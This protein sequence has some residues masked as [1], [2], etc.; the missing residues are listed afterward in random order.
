MRILLIQPPIEDFYITTQRLQPVGLLYIASALVKAGHTAKI[1]DLL[2]YPQTAD[3]NFD[4][5]L[6]Y[7]SEY[8][9]S[10]IS[11]FRIFSQYRRFGASTEN[12]R[13]LIQNEDFDVC[14]IASNFTCY[15]KQSLEVAMIIK[16]LFP[17]KPVVAGG[18]S[19]P[20]TWEKFLESGFFDYTIFGE[21]E[22]TFVNLLNKLSSPDSV[23]NIAFKKNGAVVRTEPRPDFDINETRM[24]LSFV[25]ASSYKIGKN[26]SLSMVTSRGCPMKCSYCT[27]T[28]NCIAGYQRKKLDLVFD[29]IEDAVNKHCISALNIE[30]ENFSLDRKFAMDFLKEKISRFPDL[31]L[32]FMNG[33]HYPSLDNEL[34]ELLRKADC[35][36]LGI[37]LVDNQN[38]DLISR[39]ADME[40][41][42]KVIRKAKEL[43]FLVTTYIIAGLPG[44]TEKNVKNLIDFIHSEGS[45][46]GVSIY[47]PIP[48]TP[49]FD[50]LYHSDPE[51]KKI[52]W[53]QMRSSALPYEQ[54]SLSRRALVNILR[55]ARMTN[56]DQDPVTLPEYSVEEKGD[57]LIIRLERQ[58][59]A[60]EMKTF[61]IS[62]FK[63]QGEFLL[64]K[65]NR[66]GH[67]GA[68]H[69]FKRIKS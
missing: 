22:R 36:N 28:M 57:R 58:F 19:I 69:E 38:T 4:D 9:E 12:I 47:Y 46:A 20:V 18:N 63:K 41:I 34:L 52:T 7:L 65:E 26:R 35:F 23:N 16:S 40:K 6:S 27:A 21:G 37:A 54:P 24:D 67:Y 29:E 49:L 62:H 60:P 8:Y 10:D 50:N 39:P 66:N 59:T 3:I 33:L 61:I 14:G 31:R 32:Y 25:D 13:N 48:G 56:L 51:M 11:P 43:G 45:V 17:H 15:W 64:L 53:T 55:Y 5:E 2:A 30:D 68:D 42:T 1:L 44:Q